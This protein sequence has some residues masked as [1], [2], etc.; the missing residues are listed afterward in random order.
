MRTQGLYERLSRWNLALAP[1]TL[2]LAPALR[3]ALHGGKSTLAGAEGFW[4][5]EWRPR[6]H[7]DPSR[8]RFLAA[9]A[10][11]DSTR[12]SCC[13]LLSS[14]PFPRKA[15]HGFDNSNPS[16]TT[17]THYT[18]I[19][20]KRELGC[21]VYL[22]QLS[23]S[24][25]ECRQALAGSLTPLAETSVY[26]CARARVN[27]PPKLQSSPSAPTPQNPQ[28]KPT[29]RFRRTQAVEPKSVILH[30]FSSFHIP[31]ASPQWGGKTFCYPQV[32]TPP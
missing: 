8:R 12:S 4:R 17:P 7:I 19:A 6:G 2:Y 25:M 14:L 11:T 1:S 21:V 15:I 13:P 9:V 18:Y 29:G 22:D 10:V 28:G 26:A 5:W 23:D 24:K 16:T 31:S 27:S 30:Y 32:E 20:L 3:S